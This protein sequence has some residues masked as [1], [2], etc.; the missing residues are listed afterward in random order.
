[1]CYMFRAQDNDKDTTTSGLRKYF[2][3]KEHIKLLTDNYKE[4]LSKLKD[5]IVILSKIQ[6]PSA[7]FEFDDDNKWQNNNK[8][9]KL[10]HIIKYYT[11]DLCKYLIVCFYLTHKENKDFEKQFIEFLQ[12]LIVYLIASYIKAPNVNN[13]KGDILQLDWECVANKQVVPEFKFEK[14]KNLLNDETEFFKRFNENK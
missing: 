6:Y 7:S 4:T 8:I 2:L 13:I 9:K 5:I 14:A 3:D 10:F 11:N 12:K 1:M